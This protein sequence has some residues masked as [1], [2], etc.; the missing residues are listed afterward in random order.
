MAVGIMAEVPLTPEQYDQLNEKINFPA[1]VPDGLISH[2]AGPKGGGFF[3]VD[4]WESREQYDKFIE[5]T[6]MPAFAE[7]VGEIGEPQPPQE[8]QVHNRYPS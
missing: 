6:L 3:V 5:G 4:V 2:T 7:V 8:F 1:E